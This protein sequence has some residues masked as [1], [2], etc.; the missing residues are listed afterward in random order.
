MISKKRTFDL[1]LFFLFFLLFFI[2]MIF[3]SIAILLDSKGPIL[4]WQKRVGKNNIIFLMPKFR[5]MKDKT[6][7][8]ATHKF[9]TKNAITKVGKFLRRYSLDELPQIFSI[10]SGKMSFVGPRPA[11]FNQFDL[12]RLRNKY[13][14][15]TL[16][17]G[18]TGWAQIKGRDKLSIKEKV[19][20]DFYY[21][22]NQSFL[23]DLKI[24]LNT[25]LVIFTS[26]D[27]LH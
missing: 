6:K 17:P 24:I 9:K 14:I 22:K 27:I 5:S 8:I 12:I 10:F 16:L 7:N 4:F 3:I 13:K 18:L 1:M 21:K 19:L 11:L 20:K 15:Y 2:P 26:K 23:L 25:I